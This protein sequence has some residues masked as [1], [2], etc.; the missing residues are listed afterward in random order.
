MSAHQSTPSA[1]TSE[2]DFQVALNANP[3]DHN[4]RLVFADWLQNRNDPRAEAY[5]ASES[6]QMIESAAEQWER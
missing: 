2:N 3:D 1:M 4:T 5:R 6:L